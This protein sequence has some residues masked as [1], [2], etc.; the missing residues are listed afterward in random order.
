[1]NTTLEKNPPCRCTKLSVAVHVKAKGTVQGGARSALR[2]QIT[3]TEV[4]VKICMSCF[5]LGLELSCFIPS[6]EIIFIKTVQA[7]RD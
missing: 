6:N 4:K 2:L 3:R 7:L 5:T 1:M